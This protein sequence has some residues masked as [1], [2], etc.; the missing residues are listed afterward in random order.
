VRARQPTRSE[1][2]GDLELGAEG[3]VD[4]RPETM[5]RAFALQGLARAREAA[6]DTAAAD[7]LQGYANGLGLFA[8]GFQAFVGEGYPQAEQAFAASVDE[9]RPGHAADAAR[10]ARWPA[11]ALQRQG[12]TDD[13]RRRFEE[14]DALY[15]GHG[16][17]AA[18]HA[19]LLEDFADALG[20]DPQAQ[21]LRRRAARLRQERTG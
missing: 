21:D 16:G 19:T 7:S 10:S 8:R 17:A 9:L 15:L 6:G 3:R 20:D 5:S 11:R 13:A 12:R 14:A 2:A 4:L 1:G 18:E